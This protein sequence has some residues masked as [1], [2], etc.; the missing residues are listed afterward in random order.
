M[1]KEIGKYKFNGS[2][3]NKHRSPAEREDGKWSWFDKNGYENI[4]DTRQLSNASWQ[5]YKDSTRKKF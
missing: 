4:S 1:G 2:P 5:H 3:R